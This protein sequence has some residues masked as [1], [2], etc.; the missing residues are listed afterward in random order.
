MPFGVGARRLA[1]VSCS[2]YVDSHFLTSARTAYGY[3][4]WLWLR[5]GLWHACPRHQMHPGPVMGRFPFNSEDRVGRVWHEPRQL[6][7]L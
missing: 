1:W 3:R 5:R 4:L 2:V 7:R 6:R